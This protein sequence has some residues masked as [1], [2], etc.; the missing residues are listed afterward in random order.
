MRSI[1]LP[2][3]EIDEAREARADC[4]SLSE[5]PSPG[6]RRRLNLFKTEHCGGERK[7]WRGGSFD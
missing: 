2:L 4:E 7:A 3:P 6:C 1:G 5:L